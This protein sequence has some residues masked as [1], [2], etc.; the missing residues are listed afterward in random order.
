MKKSKHTLKTLHSAA[1]VRRAALRHADRAST[2]CIT[3]GDEEGEV[4]LPWECNVSFRVENKQIFYLPII[5]AD[6]AP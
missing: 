1:D 5:S 3:E 2:T 4:L 6:I